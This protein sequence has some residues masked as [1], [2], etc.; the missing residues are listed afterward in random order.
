MFRGDW[1]LPGE[2]GREEKSDFVG[3]TG[4]GASGPAPALYKEFGITAD[5]VVA[6]VKAML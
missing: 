2:R 3:M 5:N 4:F 6:R 1:L